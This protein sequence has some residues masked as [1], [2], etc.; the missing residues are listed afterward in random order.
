MEEILLSGNSSV[1]Q[2]SY[3]WHWHIPLYLFLGGLA[4]GLLFFASLYVLLNKEKE[5]K[6]IV[7]YGPLIASIAIVIGLVALLLDLTNKPYFWRLYTTIRLESPMSW[8]AW[9]LLAITP[10]G[11]VWSATYFKEIWPSIN[12]K[13]KLV[14][15]LFFPLKSSEDKSVNWD[16]RW[17]W[18]REFELFAIK[19]RKNMARILVVL[20]P[21]LGIYT[22]ILLSAFNARPL[23]NTSILGPLFLVSGL[24]TA[25]ALIIIISKDHTE[26][27]TIGKVDLGLIA[28]ELFLITHL[29][30]GSFAGNAYEINA[31]QLFFGGEF[32]M[33][34]WIYVIGLGLL[35]PALLEIIELRGKKIPA[36]LIALPVLFGGF[37]FRFIIVEAGQI[38][39]FGF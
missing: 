20:A 17:K 5:M 18:L 27:K 26:R 13:N 25:A 11:L 29:F 21:V 6:T 16:W 7:K 28:V 38:N 34:F 3:T 8:G 23:W 2:A 12:L 36:L 9:T 30:M 37:M 19:Q 14:G 1:E 32:T 4:A 35:F 24:S 31:A 15:I 10:I 39:G 22:G 33:P